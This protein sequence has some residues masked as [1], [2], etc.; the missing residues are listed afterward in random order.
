MEAQEEKV[1]AEFYQRFFEQTLL[2]L[3]RDDPRVK[4]T[5]NATPAKYQEQM[6]HEVQ[7]KAAKLG[8]A[9]AR[10]LR[11]RNLTPDSDKNEVAAAVRKVLRSEEL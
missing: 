4:V 1:V 3:I 8:L 5:F 10:E 7:R 2:A 9:L 11:S 6:L